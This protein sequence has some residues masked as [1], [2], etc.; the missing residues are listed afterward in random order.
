MRPEQKGFDLIFSKFSRR[1]SCVDS[2]HLVKKS[3]IP[4]SDPYLPSAF[5]VLCS[6]DDCKMSD[7]TDGSQS[8]AAEPE[9][10][11][12]LQVF[13]FVQFGS[14]EPFADD[15]HVIFSDSAAVV[16]NLKHL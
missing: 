3:I 13:E 2:T 12:R 16:A 8:F 15:R 7:M 9:G 11:D 1:L 6:R 4:S 14:G 5:G 10:A